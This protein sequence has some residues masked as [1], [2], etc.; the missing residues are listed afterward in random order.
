LLARGEDDLSDAEVF[1]Q[2]GGEEYWY[3]KFCVTDLHRL[4]CEVD[5]ILTCREYTQIQAYH[6][7][8]RAME[9]LART[10]KDQQTGM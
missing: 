2:Q 7:I 10:F 5:P 8:E 9:G 3:T 1:A 6:M 4:P